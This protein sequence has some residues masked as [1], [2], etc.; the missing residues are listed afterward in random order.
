M[1]QAF[2]Q[3]HAVQLQKRYDVLKVYLYVSREFKE[4][5]GSGP[6]H[7]LLGRSRVEEQPRLRNALI[8]CPPGRRGLLARIMPA[9]WEIVP[10]CLLLRRY[11]HNQ[12]P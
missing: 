2:P 1:A 9:C 10:R 3:L 4:G 11:Y 5:C 7:W 12:S 6:S 8:R